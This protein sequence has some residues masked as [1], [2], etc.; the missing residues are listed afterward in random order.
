M[1]ALVCG[2]SGQGQFWRQER[3]RIA[4]VARQPAAEASFDVLDPLSAYP[5]QHNL[6]A[7]LLHLSALPLFVSAYPLTLGT[8]RP[9]TD[10]GTSKIG[11]DPVTT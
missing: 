3:T 10:I 8:V 1:L 11:H 9:P 2:P 4:P 7:P 5:R 6:T